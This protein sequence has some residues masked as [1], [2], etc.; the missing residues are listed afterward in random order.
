MISSV[1]MHPGGTPQQDIAIGTNIEKQAMSLQ[2]NSW[3]P[4]EDSLEIF[5]PQTIRSSPTITGVDV[6]GGGENVIKEIAIPLPSS[7]LNLEAF[8][9]ARTDDDVTGPIEGNPV[10]VISKSD[11]KRWKSSI[12]P[13]IVTT[14]DDSNM[15]HGGIAAAPV[16]GS[17]SDEEMRVPESPTNNGGR[18]RNSFGLSASTA[19]AI[20]NEYVG[21]FIEYV[22]EIEGTDGDDEAT[23]ITS[24]VDYDDDDDM[25]DDDMEEEDDDMEGDVDYDAG[26]VYFA[27]GESD[28]SFILSLPV[29]DWSH[30]FDDVSVLTIDSSFRRQ[31]PSLKGHGADDHDDD[32]SEDNEYDGDDDIEDN[33]ADVGDK[34]DSI[35]L[36]DMEARSGTKPAAAVANVAVAVSPPSIVSKALEDVK[37]M[38]FLINLCS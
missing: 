27:R 32:D 33:D 16:P 6:F 12:P 21:S 19:A 37:L 2:V 17:L 23:S 11:G 3:N 20:L 5:S 38:G 10:D 28:V 30:S 7:L 25:E 4:W 31:R 35:S 8:Q 22:K 36:N 13:M 34:N 1:A 14:I 18:V 15:V 24:D 9:K 26:D 29:G